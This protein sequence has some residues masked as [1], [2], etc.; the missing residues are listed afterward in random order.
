[1]TMHVLARHPALAYAN[2]LARFIPTHH[3]VTA[4]RGA[5]T[6]QPDVHVACID[7]RQSAALST[8]FDHG[9]LH[10]TAV[11]GTTADASIA[12]IISSR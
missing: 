8:S 5:H 11:G 12:R 3:A 7:H 9:W 2:P 10:E 6:R 4:L 1:M